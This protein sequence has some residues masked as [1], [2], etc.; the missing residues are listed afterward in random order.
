MNKRK[1][2]CYKWATGSTAEKIV[3]R[4]L[5]GKIFT[6]ISSVKLPGRTWKSSLLFSEYLG[7]LHLAC[8]ALIKCYSLA[9]YQC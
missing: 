4:L 2:R 7:L 1:M 8:S 6:F 3:V 9:S 5:T